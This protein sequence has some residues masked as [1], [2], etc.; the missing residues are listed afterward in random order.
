MKSETE[1]L[2]LSL[3]KATEVTEGPHLEGCVVEGLNPIRY[4]R[5]PYEC[6]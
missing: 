1:E 3:G 4:Q 5:I 2:V 6:T